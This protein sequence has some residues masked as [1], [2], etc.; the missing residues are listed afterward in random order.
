MACYWEA[1]AEV[2]KWVGAMVSGAAAQPHQSI[3]CWPS[4]CGASEPAGAGAAAVAA[5]AFA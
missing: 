3:A 5:G 4:S 2:E 1:W